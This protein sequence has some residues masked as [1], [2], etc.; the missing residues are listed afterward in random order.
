MS[1]EIERTTPLG[2]FN[3]AR[4]YW[5][6]AEYLHAAQLKLTH[7]TAPVSFLF[8]HAIELY[9]K[10]FL[11]SQSLTLKSLKSIG[12]RVDKAGEK[13]IEMGLLL[14]DED[15][16]VISIIGDGDTV[17]NSRYIVTGAFS[18]PA[19]DALSRTCGSLDETV[20]KTLRHQGIAVREERFE[21]PPKPI[22]DEASD[23]DDELD[24]LSPKE[25]EILAYLLAH[26]QRVFTCA[27][28]GGHAIT[29]MSRGIVQR[30]IP[31]GQPFHSEDMP[32]E[33]P[34]DA[35]KSLQRRRDEFP[36][37][38]GDGSHPWRVHWME[39]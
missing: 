18:R 9:L 36:Y 19:E 25:R 30:A 32:V 8:Y 13:A 27:L 16:E 7:P 1:D 28:D 6:S 4:S 31:T 14:L 11:L 39:R 33:I 38:H 23:I 22:E 35:W 17:I 15:K 5:R 10:A 26:N 29:L 37:E 20:G 24:D 2:L 34:R 12:H 21:L 3:Y